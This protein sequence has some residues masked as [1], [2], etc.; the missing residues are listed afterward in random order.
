MCV[1]LIE[2]AEPRLQKVSWEAEYHW[3]G[4]PVGFE[5]E[6]FSQNGSCKGCLAED[7][8]AEVRSA[9][10]RRTGTHETGAEGGR[11]HR[12]GQGP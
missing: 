6:R 7:P 11:Q 3:T 9:C 1:C 4:C 2:C 8:E 12:Q 5:K 10:V